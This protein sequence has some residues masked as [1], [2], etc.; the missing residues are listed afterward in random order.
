MTDFLNQFETWLTNNHSRFGDGIPHPDKISSI[1]KAVTHYFNT[2]P[3]RY[4]GSGDNGIAFQSD[5][6]NVIKFTLDEREALLWTR[7]KNKNQPGIA[8]LKDIANLTSSK[9]GNSLVYVIKAEFAPTSITQQQSKLIR[10]ALENARQS[11]LKDLEKLQ[12]KRTPELH[13]KRR[14]INLIREFQKVADQDPTFIN[15]PDMIMDIA[16]KY[17][18]YIYD[19]QPDNFKINTHGEA[20]I[21]DPSIPDIIG[22]I[23]RPEELLYE[24]RLELALSC[25]RLFY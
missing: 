11:T 1:V 4:I 12:E 8:Q 7:L 14:T 2:T 20:I 21:I 22:E 18:A 17:G 13:K 3:I 10:S 24:D 15:I 16:D 9:T 5:D 25:Y 23:T 19:L 6:G